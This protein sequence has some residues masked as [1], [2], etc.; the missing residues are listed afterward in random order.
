[1]SVSKDD[2][3]A[4]VNSVKGQYSSAAELLIEELLKW[5]PNFEIMEAFGV[6]FPQ[7]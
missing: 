3:L 6:V 7:Y 5:F 1:M 4:A 2:F